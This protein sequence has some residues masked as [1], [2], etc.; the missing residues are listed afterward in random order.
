MLPCVSTLTRVVHLDLTDIAS[1][2][3]INLYY[4]TRR[5]GGV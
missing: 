5:Y 4:D 3:L 2:A 1:I